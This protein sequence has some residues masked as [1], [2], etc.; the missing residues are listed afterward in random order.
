M[1]CFKIYI[2]VSYV[3]FM[4]IITSV[5]EKN[6]LYAQQVEDESILKIKSSK[7]LYY[8]SEPVW[9]EIEIKIDKSIK[10]DKSPVLLPP[11]DLEFFLTN[12]KGDTIKH[13]EGSY[14]MIESKDHSEYYFR[15]FDLLNIYGSNEDFPN[16]QLR[17]EHRLLSDDYSLVIM[18]PLYVD[19]KIEKNYSNMIKFRIEK[20]TGDE[21]EA[22]KRLIEIEDFEVNGR[23]DLK[24]KFDSL[25]NKVMEFKN[26]YEN[27]VFLNKV[28]HQIIICSFENP[29]FEDTITSYLLYRI[30]NDASN[31]YNYGYLYSIDYRLKDKEE[32]FKNSLRLIINSNKG[33]LLEK[34]I[35]NYFRQKGSKLD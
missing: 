27:S 34:F 1:K 30:R 12:S 26:N 22:H 35:K 24:V 16:S 15:T 23:L 18:L 31:Y 32:A 4:F 2:I 20:P 19:N 25:Y 3:M 5:F 8:E 7:N 10:L 28:E 21:I 14:T 6:N 9:I 29:K 11:G 17:M 13:I 33:T